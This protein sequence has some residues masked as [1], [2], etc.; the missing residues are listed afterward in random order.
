VQKKTED[1]SEI[2]VRP[3]LEVRDLCVDERAVATGGVSFAADAGRVVGIL[4]GEGGG[5]SRLLRCVGLDFAPASGA[6]YLRGVDVTGTTGE[7]RRQLR[8]RA[9]ELVHPPAPTG[10]RDTT[11]PGARAG[12]LLSGGRPT[13]APVAGMRQRIQIAKALTHGADAL[14][15]DEPFA[16][17]ESAVRQ[18]ILELLER[19]RTETDTAVV[20]ASRD[21]EVMRRIAD[22]VV[23][24]CDGSAVESG[25]T[26]RVLD[27][28]R[29]HSTRALVEARRSA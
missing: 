29:H 1:G 4:G 26:G 12:L 5:K 2:M 25:P 15:L 3:V 21:P 18:R 28:P 23:V 14:L 19:L 8:A 6:V 27:A 13:T 11:V 22:H 9:I 7:H 24:L 20:V 16:G 10:V 17:V